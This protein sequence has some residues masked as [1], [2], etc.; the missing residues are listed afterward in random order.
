M[1]NHAAPPALA[2]HPDLSPVRSTVRHDTRAWKLQ[3]WASFGIAVSLAGVGLAWLPGVDLDRAFM[4]MGYLFTLS[5][6]FALRIVTPAVNALA[7]PSAE[8]YD[9]AWQRRANFAQMADSPFNTIAIAHLGPQLMTLE[10]AKLGFTV[11]RKLLASVYGIEVRDPRKNYVF[12]N[13][14]RRSY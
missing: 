11:D 14:G 8:A 12:K 1:F 3:V 9:A 5:T 4:F 7:N 2:M 10:L 13:V 6:A